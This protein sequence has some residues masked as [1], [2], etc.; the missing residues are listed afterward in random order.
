MGSEVYL[1]QE[2]ANQ[3]TY[4]VYAKYFASHQHNSALTGSMSAVLWTIVQ[5]ARWKEGGEI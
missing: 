4:E 1:A 3:E 2:F 5:P